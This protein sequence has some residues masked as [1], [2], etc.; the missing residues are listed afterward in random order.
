MSIERLSGDYVRG[1]TKAIQD[2]I[3]IFEYT[4]PDLMHHRKQM[5]HNRAMQL[6]KIILKHREQIRDNWSGFIR[7]NRQLENF[8]W[9]DTRED[10]EPEDI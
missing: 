4:R 5:N 9:H 1:Y 7:F 8:E 3:A 2:T 6:L 10:Y